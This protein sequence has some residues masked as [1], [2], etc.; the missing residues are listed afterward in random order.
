[1]SWNYEDPNSWYKTYPSA[2]GNRQSPIN[3]DT[4]E[5]VFDHKLVER[6]L[7]IDYVCCEKGE[8]SNTGHSFMVS[9]GKNCVIR[10][11]PLGEHEYELVQFH[12]HWGDD[13]DHGSEHDV[14]HTPFPME[15][16]FVHWNKTLY[17]DA[18]EATKSPD[19]LAVVGIFAT[20]GKENYQ[21]KNVTS[22]LCHIRS[23]ESKPVTID[24][25]HPIDILPDREDLCDYWT[26]PGSLTTPPCTEN[27]T[28]IMLRH[29]IEISEEQLLE[30][31]SLECH[32][33]GEMVNNF[34]PVQALHGREIR[35][36]FE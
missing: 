5:E 35:T 22:E 36:T 23:A 2:S 24:V 20:V 33:G 18:A 14:D 10:G 19:G 30:I 34:R 25:I 31:R 29:P 21:L 9:T 7:D 16:H 8:L 3:L 1:M 15:I 17:K 26:Y 6:P 11:G 12:A 27:V 32:E 4:S 28:W 13:N